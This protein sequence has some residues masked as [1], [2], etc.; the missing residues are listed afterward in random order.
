MSILQ[1]EKGKRDGREDAKS[2]RVYH[3]TSGAPL[4]STPRPAPLPPSPVPGPG[5]AFNPNARLEWD[6]QRN[7]NLDEERDYDSYIQGYNAGY[8]SLDESS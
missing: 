4:R 3:P 8:Y 5:N 7:W 2:G 6:L 1:W